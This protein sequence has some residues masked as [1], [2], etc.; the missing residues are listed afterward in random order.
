MLRVKN[1]IDMV[2]NLKGVITEPARSEVANKLADSITATIKQ[3]YTPEA[4]HTWLGTDR[5]RFLVGCQL[6]NL[7]KWIP[8]TLK[9]KKSKLAE[10]CD[11]WLSA[12]LF[13]LRGDPAA[14]WRPITPEQNGLRVTM[15][16]ELRAL[17]LDNPE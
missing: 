14:E 6:E 13:K 5:N 1:L 17:S 3:E 4:L 9:I 7:D 8:D 10:F 15:I 12:D 16:E 2:V 11:R